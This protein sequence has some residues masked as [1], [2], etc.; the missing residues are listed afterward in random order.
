[1]LQKDLN[2]HAKIYW[3]S[4]VKAI[5]VE[6][7]KLFMS[8][9]EFQIICGEAIKIL[10]EFKGKIWIADQ[11]NSEGV[12]SQEIQNFI[13]GDLENAAKAAGIEKVLTVT[14][15]NLGLS[16]MSVK[17]WSSNVEKKGNFVTGTFETLESCKE[18]I[19]SAPDAKAS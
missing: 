19:S 6:W 4:D 11:Y 10:N 14:P 12:F 5:R 18:W 2:P 9:E 13:I 7:L 3:L 8:L 17:K 1:M 16:S 15:N